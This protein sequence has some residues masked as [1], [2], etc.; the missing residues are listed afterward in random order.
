MGGE[1]MPGAIPQHYSALIIFL[2]CS[3]PHFSIDINTSASVSLYDVSAY[4]TVMGCVSHTVRLTSQFIS[5]SCSSFD[6]IRGEMSASR[7]SSLNLRLPPL[8]M[9]SN[10]S[11]HFPL[12]RSSVSRIANNLL[13]HVSGSSLQEYLIII[14]NFT[15]VSFL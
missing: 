2:R 15:P 5:S 8:S 11:F 7:D 14:R 3:S 4:S 10:T 9:I 1:L 13:A 12:T 6:N